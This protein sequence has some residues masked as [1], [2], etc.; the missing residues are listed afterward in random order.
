[1]YE[2]IRWTNSNTTPHAPAP[3]W[4]EGPTPDVLDELDY[5]VMMLGHGLVLRWANRVAHWLL[6]RGT[7]LGRHGPRLQPANA[8]DTAALAE[9]AAAAINQGLRRWVKLGKQPFSLV[10]LRAGGALLIGGR[11][12]LCQA[13][14]IDGF[15]R[16]CALTS[17]EA[18]V[19][20]AL[21]AGQSPAQIARE[22]GVKLSTVR[23]QLGALRSKVGVG[24]MRALVRLVATLPPMMRLVDGAPLSAQ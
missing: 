9:A 7:P 10:P 8:A 4:P 18:Q 13:L 21:C 6:E 19:L 20:H 14:S 17:S 11:S 5:P 24:D 2:E 23:T 3:A 15:A 16:Q 12:S 22:R 1:M